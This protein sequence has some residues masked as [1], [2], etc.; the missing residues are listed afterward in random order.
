MRHIK[1]RYGLA[2]ARKGLMGHGGKGSGRRAQRLT[3]SMPN[4]YP[5][6]LP[7]P[8]LPVQGCSNHVALRMTERRAGLGPRGGGRWCKGG[9]T[10]SL[11]AVLWLS[12]GAR[13]PMRPLTCPRSSPPLQ[14]Q[15]VLPRPAGVRHGLPAAVPGGAAR[16]RPS[17]PRQASAGQTPW[18]WGCQTVCGSSRPVEVRG[19]LEGRTQ[20]G[21]WAFK[22]QAVGSW[23]LLTLGKTKK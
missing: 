14:Q 5:S 3:A 10:T 2:R 23:H 13:A 20:T 17:P 19:L 15:A 4:S 12:A 9:P 8:Q 18:Q 7:Y 6:S 1:Q 22:T 21:R 11:P 16:R